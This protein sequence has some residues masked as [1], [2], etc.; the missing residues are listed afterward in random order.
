[1]KVY[2]LCGGNRADIIYTDPT[3]AEEELA[4]R[5]H[6]DPDDFA[7]W[8]IEELDMTPEALAALPPWDE[9]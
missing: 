2:A 6:G 5:R 8:R 3:E 7:N 4:E 9:V 1:M